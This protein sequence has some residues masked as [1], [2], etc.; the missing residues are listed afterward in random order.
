MQ[1]FQ[2][3]RYL[4]QGAGDP[5]I[6]WAHGWGQSHAAF[7]PLAESLNTIGT[8]VLVDLPGFGA[9]AAPDDVWG[10]EDYADRM[11]K[12]ISAVTDAPIIWVGHSFGCRVGLQLAAKYPDLV[13][14]LCLVAGAGLPRKKPFLTKVYFKTRIAVY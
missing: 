6:V 14:K 4:Q 8:H 9:S 1:D 7:L 3:I 10:T 13:S 2:G 12:L 11:A 5:V